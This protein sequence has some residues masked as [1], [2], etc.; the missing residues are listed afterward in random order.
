MLSGCEKFFW[1]NYGA[2]HI[3]KCYLMMVYRGVLW[4]D[5]GYC[6]NCT[7]SAPRYLI[8]CDNLLKIQYFYNHINGLAIRCIT[9]LPTLRRTYG[10]VMHY[11]DIRK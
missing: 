8:Y 7:K 9:T 3:E 10:C 11:N 6:H 1:C 4:C 2:P 5:F